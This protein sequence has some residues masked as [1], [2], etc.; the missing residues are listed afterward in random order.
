MCT[1][2]RE[3]ARFQPFLIGGILVVAIFF[4]RIA[5]EVFIPVALAMLLTF[6]LA[7]VV[8]LLAR[9]RLPH[10]AAVALTV[11][12]AF[13]AIGGVTYLL[14]S[15]VTTLAGDLPKYED[16]IKRK[17][18][19]IRRAGRGGS[20]DKAQSTVKE[21]IGEL[22]KEDDP[23]ARKPAPVVVERETPGGI[24]GLREALGDVAAG[25]A[26]AGLVVVLVIFMLLERQRLLD[27]L[28]RLG[29]YRWTSRTTRILTEA[30]ERISRYLLMQTTINAAFGLAIGV[31]L[32][33]IGVPY[34]LLFAVLAAVLR[35]IP[36]VGA[37]IAASL[38]LVMALAVFDDW[39][40][41]LA[42]LG[43]FA[44]VELLIYLVIE[45]FLIGHSAGVS[46]LALLITLAFWTWLWGPIGL[47][48]GTPLTVCLVAL[49]KHVPGMEFIVVMFGDEPVVRPDV[50][51]Y[52]RLLKGDE[53]EAQRVLE[54][55]AKTHEADAV[56][57]EVILPALC[58]MRT[59]AAR[60]AVTREEAAAVIR[61][62]HEMLDGFDHTALP[63][64]VARDTG[65]PVAPA[66][67]LRVLGCAARDEVD[68]TAL[69][70]LAGRLGVDGVAVDVVSSS[71]LAAEV[72]ERAAAGDPGVIVVTAVAPGGLSQARYLIKR[73]RARY[74]ELPVVAVRWG[75]PDGREDARAQLTAAGASEFAATLREARERVLQYRQVRTEPAPSQAA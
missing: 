72:V 28:I 50:A 2:A 23:K 42:V 5:K 10:V 39:R 69:R 51:L 25:L 3:M 58:R 56:Y 40:Q 37:W 61:A 73:L 35:F 53:D 13:S 12:L 20:I 65:V 46:P 74:P 22:Q 33:F 68:E 14:A 15:Q 71:L 1:V 32:F 24:A 9:W 8:R 18:R 36:Y 70:I 60:G 31:G 43:V 34:V 66:P 19:E 21:V 16:T 7:P 26:T 17:I 52:Q 11:V 38:P 27:R 30:G 55:Y 45:P 67:G 63:A 49:G 59:D 64:A 75:P 54:E 6:V 29:G 41:P 47:V 4:L 62:M 48:L 44:G 57:D